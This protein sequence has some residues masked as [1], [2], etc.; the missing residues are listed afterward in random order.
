MRNLNRAI[1]SDLQSFITHH[2]WPAKEIRLG[3]IISLTNAELKL[4]ASL[5]NIIG[6]HS[7]SELDV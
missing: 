5:G 6:A 1:N 3:Q 7:G 2:F 4:V